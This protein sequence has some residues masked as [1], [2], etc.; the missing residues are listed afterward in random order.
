[1]LNAL[2]KKYFKEI[3]FRFLNKGKELFELKVMHQYEK[4][5]AYQVVVKVIDILGNDT[6][7]L[8]TIEI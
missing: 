1:M 8:L 2:S 4:L 3:I 5:G 6:I 7:E